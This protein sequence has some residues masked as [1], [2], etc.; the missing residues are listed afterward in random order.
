MNVMLNPT[1][2]INE[3]HK[4]LKQLFQQQSVNKIF[5]GLILSVQIVPTST[6]AAQLTCSLG[7]NLC[8]WFRIY[9][10]SM[11]ISD[12]VYLCVCFNVTISVKQKT[13]RIYTVYSYLAL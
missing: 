13:Q 11:M 12:D 4:T 10:L 7:T 9:T 8:D 2:E 5:R 3:K 1:T 6:S